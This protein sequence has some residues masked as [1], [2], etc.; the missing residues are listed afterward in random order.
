MGS[1]VCRELCDTV[2]VKQDISASLGASSCPQYIVSTKP[3]NIH[4]IHNI[5]A[6]MYHDS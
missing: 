5:H 6:L 2:I 4:N 3:V 1:Y